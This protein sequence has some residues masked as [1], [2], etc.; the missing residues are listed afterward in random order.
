MVV[1]IA[2]LSVALAGQAS[3]STPQGSAASDSTAS[4]LARGYV[5]LA[6]GRRSEAQSV[7]ERPITL[8]PSNHAALLLEI[9]ALAA[10]APVS[11]ALDA[12]E[13]TAQTRGEDMGLL[14]QSHVGCSVDR[15]AASN[16]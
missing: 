11:R 12:Y 1:A 9:E 2:L 3:R 10:G 16:T 5:A 6:A 7:A 14:A 8:Q 15:V 4:A 13:R